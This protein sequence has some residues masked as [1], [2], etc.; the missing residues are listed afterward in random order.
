MAHFIAPA[1]S[2]L[3]ILFD[4]EMTQNMVRFSVRDVCAIQCECNLKRKDQGKEEENR[5]F[6][7]RYFSHNANTI[8]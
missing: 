4:N 6:K 2:C 3:I 5:E 7:S 8:E 1:M